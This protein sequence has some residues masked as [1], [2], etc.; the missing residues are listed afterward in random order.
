MVVE[1]TEKLREPKDTAIFQQ[2]MKAWYP[3]LDPK[4]VIVGLFGFGCLFV[5]LGEFWVGLFVLTV[6]FWLF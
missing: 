6:T 5:P 2:R 4:W 3:I 1:E